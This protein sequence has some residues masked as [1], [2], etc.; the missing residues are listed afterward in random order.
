MRWQDCVIPNLFRPPC[1]KYILK[2]NTADT[3]FS[4]TTAEAET[5]VCNFVLLPKSLNTAVFAVGLVHSR[6]HLRT[7]NVHRLIL[8]GARQRRADRGSL[9]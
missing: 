2:K 3:A 9:T 1:C 8:R 6:S 7:Q 5:L 4:T